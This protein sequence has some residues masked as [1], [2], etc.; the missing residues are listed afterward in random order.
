MVEVAQA[1][2]EPI[3]QLSKQGDVVKPAAGFRTH[4]CISCESPILVYGRLIPCLHAFCQHCAAKM[5]VCHICGAP[6][7]EIHLI[8]HGEQEIYVSAAT[9]QSFD[10]A[11]QSDKLTSQ[12]MC[13]PVVCTNA[14]Q[15]RSRAHNPSG[16]EGTFTRACTCCRP[17]P[18]HGLASVGREGDSIP[19]QHSE[20]GLRCNTPSECVP[21]A[22]AHVH[23]QQCKRVKTAQRKFGARWRRRLQCADRQARRC[24]LLASQLASWPAMRPPR[25]ATP[26]LSSTAAGSS[27][28]LPPP[29]SVPRRHSPLSPLRSRCLGLSPQRHATGSTSK[30]CQGA[31]R[32]IWAGAYKQTWMQARDRKLCGVGAGNSACYA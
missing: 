28:S 29:Q 9:L 21:A 14:S 15:M 5:S 2:T 13:M 26:P 27:A 3:V 17:S 1:G 24:R 6:I 22:D 18:F 10:S 7:D 16:Y 23:M 32:R 4:I 12:T 8:R 19:R 25:Q 11:L 30:A 20:D 31:S